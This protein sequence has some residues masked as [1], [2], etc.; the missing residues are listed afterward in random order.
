MKFSLFTGSCPEWTPEEVATHCAAQ[1]WDAVEFRIADQAPSATPGF[2]AGNRATFPL[3]GLE[4]NAARL[5]DVSG[6]VGLALSG[7]AP[8]VPLADHAN[9]E[10]VLRVAA[11]TGAKRVRFTSPKPAEDVSFDTLFTKARA[12]LEV[13]QEIARPL[14]AQVVVQ[15]HHGNIVSTAS[16]AR[17]LV[18]GLDPRAV[19][20]MHDLG[21]TTIEGREGLLSLKMGLEILGPYLAHVHIKNA[22]WQAAGTG[23]DGVVQW[24]WAWATLRKGMGDVKA[25]FRALKAVGYDGWV[26][27]EEFTTEL[28]L[29][30]RLADDLAFLKSSAAAAGYR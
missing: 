30:E 14:G 20:V 12:D 8:Y 25:Y 9:A 26:T 15:I 3:S 29:E 7:L 2:W 5:V 1:G 23:E 13:L 10:R 21:N 22:V 19:A 4:D 17:R 28:P 16:C 11:Q 6:R 27:L 18:E 24:K